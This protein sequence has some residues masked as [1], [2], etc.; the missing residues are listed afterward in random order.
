MQKKSREEKELN[1]SAMPTVV[2][3]PTVYPYPKIKKYRCHRQKH[4]RILPDVC[5]FGKRN[6]TCTCTV[7]RH[8]SF[9]SKSTA[10]YRIVMVVVFRYDMIQLLQLRCVNQNKTHTSSE[11]A[12][13]FNVFVCLP[14]C[15]CIRSDWSQATG[16]WC[17]VC[18]HRTHV[19]I[20][21]SIH[22]IYVL[23]YA[24]MRF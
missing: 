7:H 14:A 17:A 19:F 16:R 6:R 9:H 13:T 1:T 4:H 18:A 2:L 5:H 11:C 21:H 24:R 10:S 23:L 15:L 8:S 22:R 20:Y 3:F 12:T